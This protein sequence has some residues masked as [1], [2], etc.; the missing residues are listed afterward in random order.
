MIQIPRELPQFKNEAA[1][2]I[3]TGS[4]EAEFFMAKNGELSPLEHFRIKKPVFTDKE[5]L[6]QRSGL[7]RV[8]GRSGSE[9][10]VKGEIKQKFFSEL[11]HVLKR[12]GKD[13]RPDIVYL[14]TPDYLHKEVEREVEAG[15]GQPSNKAF[16]GNY[17]KH[18]PLALVEM[19]SSRAKK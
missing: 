5:G 12:L 9:K 19:I 11:A 3:V 6:F 15:L 13:E 16:M 17:L 4:Q 10:D 14:F 18:P 2:L 7:G 1:L 8:F